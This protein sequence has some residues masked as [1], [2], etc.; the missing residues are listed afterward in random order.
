VAREKIL[1]LPLRTARFRAPADSADLLVVLQAPITAIRAGGNTDAPTRLDFWINPRN[2]GRT[3]RDS[4][5]MRGS[6][7]GRMIS[8]L[9]V[10]QYFFRIEATAEGSM[11]AARSMGWTTIGRDTA[12]GFVTRGFGVSDL[13]LAT[14][15]RPA[16]PQPARWTDFGIAPVLHA[17]PKN[18]TLQLLWENYEL[19][20]RGG[21]AE[22]TI[23][24]S[25]EPMRSNAERIVASVVNALARSVGVDRERD[26][27]RYRFERVTPHATAIVDVMGLAFAGTPAGDYRVVVEISDRVSGRKAASSSVFT[28]RE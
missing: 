15:A 23:A 9:P 4:G 2:E 24:V 8:R 19:G 22:Y 1:D 14:E 12:T 6:G 27:L 25:I 20:N 28:I 17:V 11:T 13:V 3:V 10:G 18:T 21:Q 26:R 5:A 16:T 7:I